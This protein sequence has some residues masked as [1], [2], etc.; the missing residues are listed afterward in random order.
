MSD[1]SMRTAAAM[2]VRE[3]WPDQ[4]DLTV[5]HR[6]SPAAD[7]LGPDFDYAAEFATLDLEAL[8]RDLLALM[9]DSQEWWPADYGHYG[10]P[11]HPHGLAQRRYLPHQRR[12]RRRAARARSA[13]PRSTAGRTTPTST[14][15]A[16]CCG[17]SSGSTAARSPGPT[18]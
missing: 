14:R 16:G 5:L 8:R 1:E 12:S 10:P 18:S 15:R 6:N 2:T 17:R 13:S 4:L 3:W 11:V 9:T 7:P